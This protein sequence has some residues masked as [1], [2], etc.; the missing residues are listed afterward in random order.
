MGLEW[1]KTQKKTPT[2]TLYSF[3]GTKEQA[4]AYAKNVGL[5]PAQTTILD[6]PDQV[7][8][9]KYMGMPCPTMFAIDARGLVAFASKE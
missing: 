1:A 9:E 3:F 4:I 8:I 7:I 2:K 5:D 6:D